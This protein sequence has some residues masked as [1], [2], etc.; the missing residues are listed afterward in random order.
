MSIQPTENVAAVTPLSSSWRDQVPPR[1]RRQVVAVLIFLVVVLFF[2]TTFRLTI[3]RGDSMLPT[4]HNGQLL[5][6]NRLKFLQPPLKKGDVVLVKMGNDI[7]IKR[8]A[9]LP[10]EVIP[11]TESL[12]FREVRDYFEVIKM[13]SDFNP[14]LIW[15]EYK[16]PANNYVVLG[17]N[18]DVSEDSRRFG[19]VESGDILGHVVNPQ[20]YNRDATTYHRR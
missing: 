17:D 6:V 5:L 7:I 8:V 16:V 19:P 3:V 4:Y 2:T 14:N 11:R 20:P 12:N 10:G 9:Y 18:A 13:P 1:I 15:E